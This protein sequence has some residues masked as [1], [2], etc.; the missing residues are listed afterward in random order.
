[1]EDDLKD[2]KSMNTVEIQNETYQRQQVQQ[3]HPMLLA[4]SPHWRVVVI[5][6]RHHL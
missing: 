4:S 2:M 3:L 5:S 6:C 1:M